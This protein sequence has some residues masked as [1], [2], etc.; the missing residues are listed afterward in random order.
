[1]KT[2]PS[3]R[4]LSYRNRVGSERSMCVARIKV[5]IDFFGLFSHVVAIP[6][7][8]GRADQLQFVL[9]VLPTRFEVQLTVGFVERN[10][11]S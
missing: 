8:L 4:E 3:E 7:N 6:L 9:T 2:I 11:E 1:M 10:H 5:E